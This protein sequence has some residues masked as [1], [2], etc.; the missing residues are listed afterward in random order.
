MSAPPWTQRAIA[1]VHAHLAACITGEA[2]A[3]EKGHLMTA[4]GY[5]AMQD[6]ARRTLTRLEA[7]ARRV[8]TEERRAA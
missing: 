3:R 1:A 2:S 8:P 6:D 7:R 5:Q 4:Q